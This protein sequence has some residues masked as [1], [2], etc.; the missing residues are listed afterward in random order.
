M[1]FYLEKKGQ[2]YYLNLLGVNGEPI[3]FNELNL[4]YEI[5]GF[6]ETQRVQLRTNEQ[7]KVKLGK[8]SLVKK[9]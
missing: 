5:I 6:N 9:L 4:N 2:D 3:P 1:D 8:L 7:G